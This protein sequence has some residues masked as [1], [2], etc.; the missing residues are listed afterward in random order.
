[1]VPPPMH[2]ARRGTIWNIPD[3]D[4]LVHD[5]NGAHGKVSFPHF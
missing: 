2:N 3:Q 1:M 5:H 4:E